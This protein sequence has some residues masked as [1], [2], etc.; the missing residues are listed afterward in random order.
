[1]RDFCGKIVGKAFT[2]E[3]MDSLD[4]DMGMPAA[5][6]RGGFGCRHFWSMATR[7]GAEAEGIEVIDA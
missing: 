6:A 2:R 4:N 7:E 5:H 1:M 3:A